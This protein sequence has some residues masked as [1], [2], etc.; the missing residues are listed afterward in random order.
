MHEPSTEEIVQKASP[1]VHPSFEGEAILSVGKAIDFSSKGAGGIINT[2]PLTCMPGTIVSAV[3]KKCRE[4]HHNIPLL[5]I[6]YD[7]Q[8]ESNTKTRLEAFV[9]Q[10]KHYRERMQEPAV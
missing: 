3:L 1:Y 9:Y 7:G 8:K 5:N 10:V 2:M 6:A 4:G